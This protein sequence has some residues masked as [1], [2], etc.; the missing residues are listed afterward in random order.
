MPK[1]PGVDTFQDPVGHFGA[2]GGHFE[3]CRRCGVAGGERVPPGAARLVFQI[4]NNLTETN[5][6][7]H[8]LAETGIKG[9][10]YWTS[11]KKTRVQPLLSFGYKFLADDSDT[12]NAK[13]IYNDINT[14]PMLYL[15]H[16]HTNT[17]TDIKVTILGPYW[18]KTLTDTNPQPHTGLKLTS[19]IGC[20]IN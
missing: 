4:L 16:T 1:N 8:C 14:L 11:I 15:Y 12:N 17:N 7:K 3:F 18:N 20:W 6:V 5:R 10:T 2:T 19:I 9:Q 13:N